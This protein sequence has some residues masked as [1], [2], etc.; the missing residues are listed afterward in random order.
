MSEPCA[1]WRNVAVM[2][3]PVRAAGSS[4]RNTARPDGVPPSLQTFSVASFGAA[5]NPAAAPITDASAR[6]AEM[7]AGGIDL[8]VEV[9]PVALSEFQGEDYTVHEN[10]PGRQVSH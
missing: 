1:A 3:S 4:A 6:T 9:P 2:P 10:K 5:P 7:L 8:M